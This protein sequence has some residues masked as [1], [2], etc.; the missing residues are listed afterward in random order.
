VRHKL[1]YHA[2]RRAFVLSGVLPLRL[3]FPYDFGF[4]L[5]TLGGDGDPLDVLVLADE[6][7]PPGTVVP[8]LMSNASRHRLMDR[9][10]LAI[11]LSAMAFSAYGARSG[12]E[13]WT[14]PV[15]S[16][17]SLEAASSRA[18]HLSLQM[19]AAFG[20]SEPALARPVA[21]QYLDSVS[22]IPCDWNYGNAIHDANSVLGLLA[23]HEGNTA[24]ALL[25]LK[26]AGESPGSPQLNTFGPS[27][28]LA[29]ELAEAGEY[30]AVA[31]YISVIGKFWKPDDTTFLAFALPFLKDPDPLST[32]LK[33]LRNRQVPAFGMNASK[34]P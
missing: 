27:L 8:P 30:E 6:A 13:K 34:S 24:Q 12:C 25:Y 7:I 3:S 29:N 2:E 15:V 9:L 23:L 17:S 4:L 31:S 22:D 26:A 19:H 28:M 16:A 20:S 1:K 5:S 14:S 18:Y 10:S 11:M 21:L 33:A 32:W